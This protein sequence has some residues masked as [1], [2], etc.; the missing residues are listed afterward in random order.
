MSNTI[1]NRVAIAICLATLVACASIDPPTSLA[2]QAHESVQRAKEMG[3]EQ[4]A[5][6][7]LREANQYLDQAE[8]AIQQQEYK[9]AYPLLE[10]SLINSDLAISRSQAKK[11]QQA[12]LQIEENLEALKNQAFK[13]NKADSD[14]D[15]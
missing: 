12:A 4:S 6:L 13:N 14:T 11:S 7:A 2:T 10:K 8:L 1:L 15:E 3:A 5:P 9:K